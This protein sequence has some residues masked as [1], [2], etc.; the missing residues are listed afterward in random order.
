MTFCWENVHS[1]LGLKPL[2]QEDP[3]LC[4]YLMLVEERT[5]VIGHRALGKARLLLI[6]FSCSLLELNLILVLH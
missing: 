2:L 1:A 4:S 3:P 6:P 5:V